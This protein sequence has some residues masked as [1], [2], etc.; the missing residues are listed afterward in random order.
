M[1]DTHV[2]IWTFGT[3]SRLSAA[4][5]Q[6]IT[7][8]QN[9]VFVSAVTAWETAIK[10]GLGKLEQY[11][12]LLHGENSL[13]APPFCVLLSQNYSLRSVIKRPFL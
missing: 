3:D 11:S 1:L 7:D 5:R 10:R 12:E 6:A 4:A 8:G 9:E 13:P 2:L